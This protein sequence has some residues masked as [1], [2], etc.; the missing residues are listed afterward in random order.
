MTAAALQDTARRTTS[1]ALVAAALA[2]GSC[3]GDA[4]EGSA[5]S[6]SASPAAGSTVAPGGGGGQVAATPSPRPQDPGGVSSTAGLLEDAPTPAAATAVELPAGFPA[7]MPFPDGFTVQQSGPVGDDV[8]VSGSYP[9]T[10]EEAAAFYRER[11]PAAGY[12]LVSTAE[13]VGDDGSGLATFDVVGDGVT[14]TVAVRADA[15]SGVTIGVTLR[16]A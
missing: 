15:V 9:G 10:L 14:G 8:V 1:A 3:S 11:L 5:P 7:S 4:P 6:A 16:A 12:E 2:L 13:F